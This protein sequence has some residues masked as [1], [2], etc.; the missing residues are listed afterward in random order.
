M[1]QWISDAVGINSAKR[2]YPAGLDLC[3]CLPCR[4][5]E[6]S[7]AMWQVDS[8]SMASAQRGQPGALTRPNSRVSAL[9]DEGSTGGICGRVYT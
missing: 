6:H 9:D 2:W 3:L 4:H 1:Q 5:A 7:E 8:H